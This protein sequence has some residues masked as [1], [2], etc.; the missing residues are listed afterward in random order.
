MARRT[1]RGATP[2]QRRPAKKVTQRRSNAPSKPEKTRLKRP[3]RSDAPRSGRPP[4]LPI[5]YLLQHLQAA[6]AALVRLSY[7]P[8]HS[9]I[10]AAVIGIAIALPTAFWLALDNFQRATGGWEDGAPQISLFLDRGTQDSQ[11]HDIAGQIDSDARVAGVETITP[12]QALAEFRAETELEAALELLEENPLPPVLIV[13][14]STDLDPQ[15]VGELANEL[16]QNTHIERMRLDQDWVNRLHALMSLTERALGALAIMLAIAV[17]LVIG[18]TIKLTI[19][20]RREEIEITKLIGGSN[21][22]VRRPF[23][24][25]GFWCGFFGGAVA[26]LLTEAARLSLK[27]PVQRVADAYTGDI[28]LQGVGLTDTLV[29]LFGG[30]LLGLLGAWLAVGRHLKIIEPR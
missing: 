17:I 25:E 16:A 2:R 24:Y 6:R 29:L 10:T 28:A 14:A 9:L 1:E 21:G 3:K 23:L 13:T 5:L 20:S 22:F 18:N 27:E 7:S 15:E 19:E 30:G 4:P 11:L 26:L 12:E 8:L